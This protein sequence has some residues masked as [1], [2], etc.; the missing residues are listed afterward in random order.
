MN[1]EKQ[2]EKFSQ[3]H[4]S[5]HSRGLTR[6]KFTWWVDQSPLN[7]SLNFEREIRM[8][9]KL[10]NYMYWSSYGS[11]K[12]IGRMN[13]FIHVCSCWLKN[14]LDRLSICSIIFLASYSVLWKAFF[15]LLIMKNWLYLGRKSNL[16]ST[17]CVP[18]MTRS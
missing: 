4:N 9:H 7:V 12:L 15:T 6:S 16:F 2:K 3:I 13:R 17:T 18:F 1:Q 10:W 14:S 5:N 8:V 11:D